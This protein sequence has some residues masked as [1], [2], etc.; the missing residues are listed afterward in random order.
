LRGKK[1]TRRRNMGRDKRVKEERKTVDDV[2][3]DQRVR[4]AVRSATASRFLLVDFVFGSSF[5]LFYVQSSQ[6]FQ[7]I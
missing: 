6:M 1:R 2:T 3:D 7:M 4:C 5:N